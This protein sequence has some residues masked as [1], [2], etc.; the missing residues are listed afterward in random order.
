MANSRKKGQKTKTPENAASACGET[1]V[2]TTT[3]GT[4]PKE[5]GDLR[6][7]IVD[8]LLN[9]DAV[10]QTIINAVS[11]ALVSKLLAS[12]DFM[13]TLADKLLS[14]GALDTVKQ[15]VYE[16]SAMDNSR[17]YASVTAMEGK[18]SALDSNNKALSDEMDALEQYSRRN[19]LLFHGVPETDADDTTESVIS[20]CKGKL[21]VDVSRDLIDRSHRL[22]QRHVGPSGE[23]KPRPIIVK[24]R[25]YET[26]YFTDN[27]YVDNVHSPVIDI[28]N[29]STIL[30][31]DLTDLLDVPVCSDLNYEP[32]KYIENN[33]YFMCE[34]IDP[35]SNIHNKIFVDSLY[36]TESEFKGDLKFFPRP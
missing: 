3:T 2:K 19:C 30:D 26:E 5:N 12:K 34:A 16:A 22:G 33:N 28:A 9:D 36:Y 27:Y 35:D 11:D 10:M 1:I 24:F 7:A 8:V 20:L 4:P 17:T 18:L 14:H 15:S 23:Y 25:S 31:N 29:L 32:F 6:T 21:D 13:A